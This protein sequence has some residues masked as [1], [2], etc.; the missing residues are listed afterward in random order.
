MCQNQRPKHLSGDPFLRC[1]NHAIRTA[2]RVNFGTFWLTRKPKKGPF[3]PL[4]RMFDEILSV[5]TSRSF[6]SESADWAAA[7][8]AIGTR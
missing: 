8:R 3:R 1:R 7:R 6:D 4:F 2:Y 5:Q